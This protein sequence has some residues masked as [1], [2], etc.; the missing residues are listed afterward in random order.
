MK[1]NTLTVIEHIVS[2]LKDAGYNPYEQLFAY[3]STGNDSYITRKG[4]ART[5]IAGVDREQLMQYLISK[6]TT[7]PYDL[8]III[9]SGAL[10]EHRCL[11]FFSIYLSLSLRTY[12]MFLFSF[13][14]T[15]RPS[16]LLL[17]F[18]LTM[19]PKFSPA[20][21]LDNRRRKRYNTNASRAAVTAKSEGIADHI[22]TTT[23]I[24]TTYSDHRHARTIRIQELTR[25]RKYDFSAQE[26]TKK[27]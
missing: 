3:A 18:S 23:K 7:E 10:F 15:L 11:L 22:L 20:E 26:S 24:L 4:I 27:T 14:A 19:H 9:Y 2:V 12:F 1:E 17:P 13:Q 5:L 21:P 6:T 8:S 16:L 25:A